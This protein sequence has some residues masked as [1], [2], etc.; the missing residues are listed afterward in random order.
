MLSP[1]KDRF[2]RDSGPGGGE[3]PSPV[4]SERFRTLFSKAKSPAKK[5]GRLAKLGRSGGRV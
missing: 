2:A 5:F 1:K 4:G 3:A